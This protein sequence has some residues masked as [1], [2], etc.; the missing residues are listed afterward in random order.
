MRQLLSSVAYCHSHR[1]VHR[2]LKPENLL[3]ESNRD[4]ALL[5]VID[6]G[7]SQFFDPDKK[8]KTKQGTPY[9]IA[10]EVIKKNYNEKCD[11]W[12]CGV[13]MFVLLSGKPPYLGNG[14]K[15]ILE[16]VSK[17]ALNLDIPEI[18]ALS[19]EAKN[20]LY[21]MLKVTPSKR[22]TA[23]QALNHPWIK[24]NEQS[25]NCNTEQVAVLNNLHKFQAHTKLEQAVYLYI[26]T[27]LI[28]N[29]EKDDLRKVFESMD[30]NHDGQLSKDELI[31]GYTKIS[32]SRVEAEAMVNEIMAEADPDGN[33]VLDYTEFLVA[34]CNK[35]TML[36]EESLLRTFKMFD[37]DSSGYITI[38][39][40]KMILGCG[41]TISEE[42]WKSVIEEVDQNGDGKISYEEFKG[43]MMK[44]IA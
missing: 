16:Q 9:Y 24:K 36:S 7:T 5:K 2:D 12:S 21:S 4:D 14:E 38:D 41:K 22:C 11:V 23:L 35:K 10:P 15:E 37:D 30:I 1:I 8:M 17:G 18:K 39:E 29:K 43:M 34:T 26:M 27:Q 13:I 19:V 40:V 42:A 20:L 3:F 25:Q 6:F 44:F 31:E 28:S 33:G 32:K